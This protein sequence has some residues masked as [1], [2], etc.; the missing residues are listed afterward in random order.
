MRS[1]VDTKQQNMREMDKLEQDTT[2][3]E[4]LSGSAEGGAST[5]LP[6]QDLGPWQEMKT[7]PMMRNFSCVEVKSAVM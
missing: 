5:T 1:V 4:K 3:V 6:S 2:F 7:L